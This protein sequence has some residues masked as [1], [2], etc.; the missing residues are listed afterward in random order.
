LKHPSQN[1]VAPPE[2]V[3]ERCGNVENNQCKQHPTQETVKPRNPECHI[4]GDCAGQREN[5]QDDIKRKV[6][7]RCKETFEP[8]HAFNRTGS[9]P[10]ETEAQLKQHKG[11]D[12]PSTPR[13]DLMQKQIK[14][15]WL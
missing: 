9:P 14:R 2:M 15:A 13:M 4:H 12:G 11:K 3:P 5:N 10:D 7:D 6:H 8:R 1:I